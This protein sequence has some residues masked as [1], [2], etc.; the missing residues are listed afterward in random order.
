[1]LL[2]FDPVQARD[3]LS[4]LTDYRGLLLR[5]RDLAHSII[6]HVAGKLGW[7]SEVFQSGRPHI[8]SWW[9]YSRYGDKLS[10]ALRRQLAADINWWR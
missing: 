10:P 2:R 3:L 4:Q 8:H 1:M 7:Y 5:V 6:R 9:L